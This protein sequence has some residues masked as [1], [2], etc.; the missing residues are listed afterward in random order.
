MTGG[1]GGA[2]EYTRSLGPDPGT[3][4]ISTILGRAA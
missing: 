4:R 3:A 1:L 2:A